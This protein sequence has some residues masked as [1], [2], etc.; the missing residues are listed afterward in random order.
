MYSVTGV[1]LRGYSLT[2]A[3]HFRS[4]RAPS[5]VT[6]WSKIGLVVQ[7]LLKSVLKPLLYLLFSVTRSKIRLIEKK[8]DLKIAQTG[9]PG[10]TKCLKSKLSDKFIKQRLQNKNCSFWKKIKFVN[11]LN[12]GIFFRI[13]E[14]VKKKLYK[15]IFIILQILMHFYAT[16]DFSWCSFSGLFFFREKF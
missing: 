11:W 13:F 12:R 7:Q 6:T 4:W 16:S 8:Y 5:N 10:E 1:P 15:K 9:T 2:L 14:N 3:R